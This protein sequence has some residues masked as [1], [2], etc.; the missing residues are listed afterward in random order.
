MT[1]KTTHIEQN[2]TWGEILERMKRYKGEASLRAWGDKGACVFL[3]THTDLALKF[4]CGY[5]EQPGDRSF[6][7]C[8][9]KCHEDG[10]LQMGWLPSLTEQMT[11]SWSFHNAGPRDDVYCKSRNVEEVGEGRTELTA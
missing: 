6:N 10:Q 3:V 4:G 5:G 9:C 7:D 2:L 8:L 1:T 11:T